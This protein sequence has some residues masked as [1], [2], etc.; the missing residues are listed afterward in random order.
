MKLGGNSGTNDP[1]GTYDKKMTEQTVG[2]VVKT[3]P[4]Y[5]AISSALF[6]ASYCASIKRLVGESSPIQIV[7]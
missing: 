4:I 7:S 3:V 2:W 1:G 6:G 5:H